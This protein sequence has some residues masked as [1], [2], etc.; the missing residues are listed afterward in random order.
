MK[1]RIE[2]MSKAFV[3]H[4]FNTWKNK[5]FAMALMGI[6]YVST[7]VDGDAT[8]FV[9]TIIFGMPLIFAKDSCIN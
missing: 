6:G 5:I 4:M 3:R 7:L 2:K 1:K 9:M 8:F